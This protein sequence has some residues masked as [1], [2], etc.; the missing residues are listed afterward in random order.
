MIP[1]LSIL[2]SRFNQYI[3]NLTSTNL[4]TLILSLTIYL[5]FSSIYF[6]E[7]VF[8]KLNKSFSQNEIFIQDFVNHKIDH[9]LEAT[10][11]KDEGDHFMKRELRISP[12]LVGKIFHLNAV[13]LFYL[14]SLSLIAFIWFFFSTIKKLTHNDSSVAFWSVLAILFTYV[15]NSFNFDTLFYD[16]FAYLGLMLSIYFYD[17][18]ISILFLIFSFFVDERAV[19]PSLILPIYYILN[20]YE[21]S[22][23]PTKIG[24]VL[25]LLIFKNK[26]FYYVAASI[27]AYFL[28]RTIL[29]V[30]FDLKTPVGS[31]SGVSIGFALRHGMNMIYAIYYALKIFLIF[32][33]LAIYALAVNKHH[34]LAISLF[35][36][37]FA[38]LLI[39]TSVDDVTR[40]MSFSFILIF[41]AFKLAY[42]FKETKPLRHILYLMFIVHLIT[43]TY[44]LLL[45]LIPMEPWR[46]AKLF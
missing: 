12:Y 17:K 19:I 23:I 3:Q 13:K 1:H 28:I 35:L 6:P 11:N 33:M 43:P 2:V 16:S 25:R 42:E 4:G 37:F 38:C 40:S 7:S 31:N 24:E 30:Q 18:K 21:F 44:T 36:I 46:W 20:N 27:S 9:P 41:I 10:K 26:S 32:P 5:L 15:G 22:K 39:S 45:S 8:K 34:W 29:Y 14:Q